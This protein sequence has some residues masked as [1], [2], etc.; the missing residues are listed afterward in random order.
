MSLLFEPFSLRSIRLKNRIVD[1]A[2]LYGARAGRG[3]IVHLTTS[4]AYSHTTGNVKN[5][6]VKGVSDDVFQ[7]SDYSKKTSKE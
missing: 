5:I 1:E 2:T 3:V 6:Y 7:I 4:P